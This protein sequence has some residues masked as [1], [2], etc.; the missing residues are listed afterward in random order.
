MADI[1][2]PG[3][4]RW[5]FNYVQDAEPTSNLSEGES[6]YDTGTDEAK[7]YDGAAWKKTGV[8]SHDALTNVSVSDH[9][10]RYTDEEAQDAVG[11]AVGD[12]LAYDDAGNV[13]NVLYSN[14]LT[15]DAN[16]NLAV[17]SGGIGA[18][19]VA[20]A[21]LGTG[22]LSFDPATQTELNNHASNSSAHHSKPT[23]S[24][25]KQFVG[26][27]PEPIN[28]TS[29]VE[30]TFNT[31]DLLVTDVHLE[32]DTGGYIGS[33]SIKL[34]YSDGTTT[35]KKLSTDK[36]GLKKMNLDAYGL[37]KDGTTVTQIDCIYNSQV[38]GSSSKQVRRWKIAGM[39]V[40]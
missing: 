29:T 17:A 5:L 40:A 21:S 1:S 28:T 32:L 4:P 34:Y 39:K 3:P 25:W 19:E 13:L 18:N 15:L 7:V 16:G 9:H 23:P 2:Q 20:D 33:T 38:D 14:G 10:A 22:E 30:K 24:G 27:P 31:S 36:D 26:D 35:T 6:W 11:A 12:A 8:V 37:V